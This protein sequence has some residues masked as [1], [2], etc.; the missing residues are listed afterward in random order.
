M[1]V[2]HL[3]TSKVFA[4]IEQHVF[5][6]ATAMDSQTDHVILCDKSLVDYMSGV[7]THSTTMGSRIS[8]INIIKLVLFVWKNNVDI[9]HCH[10]AKAS[11][12]GG[13][14]GLITRLKIVATIHGLKSQNRSVKYADSVIG[15]N[16]EVV[17]DI[18]QAKVIPNWFNPAHQGLPSSRT[19][20]VV[21][22][23]RLEKV[24]GFDLLINAWV[25][26]K[27]ELN[28]IGSG[29]ELLPL[30]ELIEKLGLAD[31]IKILTDHS[32]ESIEDIYKN[33]SGLIVSSLREGGPRTVLE[34]IN[35]NIPVLGTN[36]GI[37]PQIIPRDLLAKAGDQVSLTALLEEMIPLLPQLDVS[38]I[39]VAMHENYSLENACVQTKE[40]YFSL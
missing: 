12:I 39:K 9:L 34:A 1:K 37:M 40:V 18:P 30:Q 27:E 4:G 5:E 33:A 31:R 24:K 17:K 8:P 16:K 29:K 19:G 25:N 23:G 20:P 2:A 32:Y 13:W 7:P 21:A 6:L 14:V 10:G 36:V 38:A 28:I 22:V 26:I 15:V 35:H 11:A 3:I